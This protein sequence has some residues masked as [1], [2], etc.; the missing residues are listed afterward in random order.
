MSSTES[1]VNFTGTPAGC[2]NYQWDASRSDVALAGTVTR[3][4]I[5]V[6]NQLREHTSITGTGIILPFQM[7]AYRGSSYRRYRPWRDSLPTKFKVEQTGSYWYHSQFRLPGMTGGVWRIVI[8]PA[9]RRGRC[10]SRPDYTILL[11]DWTDEDPMRVLSKLK[12]QGDYYN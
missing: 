9:G 4:T 8:D 11:S 3:V 2:D 12:V 6:T 10:P 5:R 7:D 1:V